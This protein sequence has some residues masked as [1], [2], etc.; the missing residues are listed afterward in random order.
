MTREER[1][2]LLGDDV[3]DHIHQCVAE[4]PA[5]P[6]EVIDTLRRIFARPA[7]R[8]AAELPPAADQAA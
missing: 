3:I 5:P 4:A 8:T 7:R 1:R 6:Q 2:A